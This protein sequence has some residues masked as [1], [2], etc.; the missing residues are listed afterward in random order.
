MKL[1][2]HNLFATPDSPAAIQS[3]I[4]QFPAEERVLLYTIYMMTYNMMVTTF[5]CYEK[6]EECDSAST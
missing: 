1:K 2:P 3:Y 5:N 6:E 4:E